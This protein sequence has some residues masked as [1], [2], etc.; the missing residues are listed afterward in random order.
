MRKAVSAFA[1]VGA[2]LTS[3]ATFTPVAGANGSNSSAQLQYTTSSESLQNLGSVNLAA[4]GAAASSST[5][6]Q[7]SLTLGTPPV[8]SDSEG[9]P[10]RTG[11]PAA[12]VATG[13]PLSVQSSH[14]NGGTGFQG[15]SGAQQAAVNPNVGDLEPPDQGTCVGPDG[16]GR[17]LVVEIINNA[18]AAFT[19]SGTQVLPVTPT[20]A[21]FNQPNTASPSDP[22][23]YYDSTTQRWFFTEFVVGSPAPSTQFVAVSK[24]SDPLGN[25]E[26][27]GIDTT[28]A[29]NPV[30]DCPCFGDFDQIGADANG[31]YITTNEFSNIGAAPGFN[32]TVMYALS[33]WRLELAA[34]GAPMPPVAVYQ[35][36]GDAFGSSDGSQPYHVSPASTPPGGSYAPDTEYFVESNS[37]ASSDNHLIVYALTNTGALF[38]GGTPPLAATE[39][40]SEAYAFPPD[41]TQEAGPIPL[42]NVIGVLGAPFFSTTT[43]QGI[44]TD[45]NAVQEVTYTDGNLYGE[46]D[47]ASGSP[48]SPSNA[49][50]WFNIS[51][52]T[53]GH[54]VS[55]H[56]ARQGY[57]ATSQNVMYP[58]IVVNGEGNGYMV[59]SLSGASMYPSA[60]YVA[61]N[62]N[63]GPVGQ[64]NVAA[65]G[66][67][68]EDGFTCYITGYGG[69]RWGDYSGGAVWNGQAYLMAEYIP[70]SGRD[71]FTNWSTFVWSA[72]TH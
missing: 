43:P 24:T 33:K 69:C 21:L 38:F 20:F 22:R 72:P 34:D 35:I 8:V 63:A 11:G 46:L 32:G 30:G 9:L 17:T 10:N 59:F 49:A 5:S 62:A 58:D 55:A 44:Q 48:S 16:H 31:F 60:A 70:S 14:L 39:I 15:I 27:F 53:W 23:C 66:A 61:F 7:P 42:G 40:A 6:G 52:S 45:F 19:P 68:P 36:T 13:N 54:A 2:L 41:A 28:D 67:G 4:A 65:S 25:Y 37:N 26:V 64:V 71:T 29:S 18:V 47:T 51:A 1:L 57:V 12:P 56:V 50:A 3:V